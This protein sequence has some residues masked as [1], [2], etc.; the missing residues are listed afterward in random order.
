MEPIRVKSALDHWIKNLNPEDPRYR[1]HQVEAMWAY[2]NVEQ[3][4]IPL[5]AELLQCENHNARA[6]AAGRAGLDLVPDN[7]G[8]AIP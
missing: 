8:K 3:S 4:N 2:R 7:R 6:A 1:H 5:L